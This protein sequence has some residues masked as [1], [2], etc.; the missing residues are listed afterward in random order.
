MSKIVLNDVTNLSSLSVIND[1]F[2]KIEQELQNK[3][4]YRDNPEGEPNTFENDVDLNGN[5]IYNVENLTVANSFTVNGKNIEEVVDDAIAGIEQSAESAANSATAAANSAAS[6][7]S[8]AASATASAATATTKASEA[9]TSATNAGNSATA[10]ALSATASAS[11]ATAASGSATSAASSSSTA[12]TQASNASSSASAAATSATNASNSATSSASSATAS[13]S[14]ASSAAVSAIAADASA[15]EAAAS[16]ASVND[17]NLVHKAGTETITGVKTFTQPVYAPMI[18]TNS[19]LGFRNRIINGDMRISQRGSSFASPNGAYTIDRWRPSFSGTVA[20]TVTQAADAPTGSRFQNS[21]RFAVT[22]ADAALASNDRATITQFIEGFNVS[23]LV[24]VDFTLSFWV[25]SAKTGTHCV[26]FGN[27]VDRSYI[28]TYSVIAANTWEFKTVTVVGGLPTTGTWSQTNG[29][30]LGVNFILA[31]GSAFQSTAGSWLSSTAFATSAQV[32][33]LDTIGN[34]FAITGVQLEAGTVATP[35]EHRDYGRE[36]MMC[37]RYFLKSFDGA[38]GT[39]PGDAGSIY[40]ST[41]TNAST[42]F[43][44]RVFFRFPVVMR[45]SPSVATQNPTQVWGNSNWR[46]SADTNDVSTTADN[47]NTQGCSVRCNAVP[48]QQW[49]RGALYASAEL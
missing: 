48:A 47:I 2:D 35:F 42:S 44:I 16:A 38:V 46:I 25:R 6:A 9:S 15:D 41:N 22:T 37:Q 24:G 40:T 39:T 12:T 27:D 8:S 7:F 19:S 1:N 29:L 33:C 5:N 10:A 49:A 36:L 23:D 30:G 13:A 11:S 32:N 34:I 18:V 45:A 21:L 28:T 20:F 17:A 43:D 26:S 3:V 4:H 14:S 31:A